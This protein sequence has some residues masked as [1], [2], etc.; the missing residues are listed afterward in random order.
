MKCINFATRE[1]NIGIQIDLSF[2]NSAWKEEVYL[3]Q[4][5]FKNVRWL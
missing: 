3:S 5:C 2:W 4:S 1:N